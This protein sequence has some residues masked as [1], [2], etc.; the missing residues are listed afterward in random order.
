MCLPW[1][2]SLSFRKKKP[3]QMYSPFLKTNS[4]KDASCKA[5]PTEVL[6]R[7]STWH[8]NYSGFLYW[9]SISRDWTTEHTAGSFRVSPSTKRQ[10]PWEPMCSDLQERPAHRAATWDEQQLVLQKEKGQIPGIQALRGYCGKERRDEL[11]QHT[12]SRS[13]I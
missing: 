13:K 6:S 11:H 7:Y 3:N 1:V 8:L 12:P 5:K 2:Q 9:N 4:R 10:Q